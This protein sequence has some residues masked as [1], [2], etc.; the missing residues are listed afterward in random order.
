LCDEGQLRSDVLLSVISGVLLM[1][2]LI[3]ARALNGRDT[4][5]LGELLEA[6]FGAV[7]DTPLS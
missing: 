4:D 3:G 5:Q 2:K 1:R 7:I 6:V